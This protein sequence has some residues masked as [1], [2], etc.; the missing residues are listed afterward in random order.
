MIASRSI[1]GSAH[2]SPRGEIGAARL[3]MMHERDQN[4][5]IEAPVGRGDEFGR[6]QVNA[7]HLGVFA[8]RRGW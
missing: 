8:A 7:R 1:S 6:Q 4:L 3:I 2:N 5:A